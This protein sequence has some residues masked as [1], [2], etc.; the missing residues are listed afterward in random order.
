MPTKSGTSMNH[1]TIDWVEPNLS[2]NQSPMCH[3]LSMNVGSHGP[4]PK[5]NQLGFLDAKPPQPSI[6]VISLIQSR[7]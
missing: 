5:Q 7:C 4:K 2:F 3:I 6:T 1:P